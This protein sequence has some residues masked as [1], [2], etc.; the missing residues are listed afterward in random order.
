MKYLL[1]V[2]IT[3]VLLVVCGES[4]QSASAPEANP[5]EPVAE[6]EQP[7]PPTVKAPTSQFAK[8]LKLETSKRLNST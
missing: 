4:Q 1:T 2:T 8:Q 5:V 7:A 3:A 6:T